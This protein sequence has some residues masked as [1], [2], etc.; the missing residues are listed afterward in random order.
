MGTLRS[1]VCVL[2]LILSKKVDPR[3]Q[4]RCINQVRTVPASLYYPGTGII[5]YGDSSTRS[6]QPKMT[7][8]LQGVCNRNSPASLPRLVVLVQRTA[9]GMTHQRLG[10]P[11]ELKPNTFGETAIGG[12]DGVSLPHGPFEGQP[13]LDESAILQGKHRVHAAARWRL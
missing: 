8:L 1:R 12:R 4:H 11:G 3:V 2:F 13:R 6:L 10:Q 9:W 7:I 5:L